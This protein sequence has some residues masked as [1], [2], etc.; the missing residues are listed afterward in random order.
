MKYT[1]NIV[2][3]ISILACSITPSHAHEG[4]IALYDDISA[5]RCQAILPELTVKSLFLFYIR[6]DGPQLGQCC[7]F[8]LIKSV[9][10]IQFG[11]PIW[12]ES[13]GFVSTLGDLESGITICYGAGDVWC[14]EGDITFLGTIPVANISDPDTFTVTVAEHPALAPEPGI[15]IVICDPENPIHEVI[16]G[17]FVFNGTC[18]SPENPFLKISAGHCFVRVNNTSRLMS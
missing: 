12:N 3:A 13:H 16:G 1:M 10:N 18:E 15:H 8:R 7:E 2:I 17:T 6:G 14:G 9:E 4:M 5:S 11:M